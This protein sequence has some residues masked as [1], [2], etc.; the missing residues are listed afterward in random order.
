V[1]KRLGIVAEDLAGRIQKRDFYE[2]LGLGEGIFLDRETFGADYLIRAPKEGGW[3]RAL[4][5]APLSERA[6]RQIV[7]LESAPAD[8]LP[9]LAPAAKKEYLDTISYRDFLLKSAGVDPIVAAYY[10]QRTHGLWGVG[11]E[12]VSALEAWA[13]GLPGFAGM[14]LPPGSVPSMGETAAGFA[15]TGG[16]VDVHLPDGGATI[17]RGLVRALVPDAIPGHTLEDLVTSHADYSRLDR[18]GSP[19][20]IRLSATVTHVANLDGGAAGV[21]VEYQR[22]HQGFRVQAKHAVLACWNMIIPHICPELPAEQKAALHELVKTPLV[23]ASVAVRNWQ[24]WQKLGV[25]SIHVPN[26]Y[27]SD[28]YLNECVAIGDY[29]SATDPA[30]PTIVRLSRTPCSPGIPEHE[31]NKVGRADILATSL[32]RYEHEIRS[33]LDRMLGA[34]GF[35]STRDIVAMT[36]NRWPHGYA[37][38]INPL[39]DPLVPEAERAHVRGRARR[40]AIT[41]ANSDAAS[42]AYMDAAIEQAHRAVGELFGA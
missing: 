35:E 29:A 24:P 22:A 13:T 19:T 18:G 14:K 30:K 3:D 10:Q 25:S 21:S 2:S 42:K 4:A 40:G 39:F 23:Y 15:D 28:V 17:A 37:P 9:K 34:G 26:G 16:S 41:I 7:A 6:R 33:Q 8:Y 36:V 32:E 5:A 11:I 27:F 20:R 31:Q 38:E 1:L 12:A